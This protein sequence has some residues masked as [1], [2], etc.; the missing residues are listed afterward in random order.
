MAAVEK[1]PLVR[2][3]R[4]HASLIHDLVPDAVG[5]NAINVTGRFL[6]R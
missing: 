6:R 3:A 5:L 1:Q 2:E 4:R